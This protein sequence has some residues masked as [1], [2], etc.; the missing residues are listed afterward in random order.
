MP[1]GWL[2]NAESA[3]GDGHENGRTGINRSTG[4]DLHARLLDLCPPP[5]TNV[6]HPSC[7][8]RMFDDK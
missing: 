4:K 3:E 7:S 5:I 8:I 2:V 6:R 1:K